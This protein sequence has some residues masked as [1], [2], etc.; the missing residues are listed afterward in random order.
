MYDLLFY[1]I[2][3]CGLGLSL[4]LFAYDIKH[5]KIPNYSVIALIAIGIGLNYASG[6]VFSDILDLVIA[7]F[8]G[9]GFL[10][11]IR[12]VANYFYQKETMGYGDIKLVFAI[13]FWVGYPNILVA[14]SVGAFLG[15]VVGYAIV[16][17]NRFKKKEST[18]LLNNPIPAGPGFILGMLI[19]F[20]QIHFH[21]FEKAIHYLL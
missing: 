14:L 21:A 4:W 18:N 7:G 10:A 15:A 6:F 17:Y 5:Y 11:I 8:V 9:A 2:F 16:A 1:I 3:A 20:I 12:G 19:S 13:G